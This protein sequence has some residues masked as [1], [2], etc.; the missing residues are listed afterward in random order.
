MKQYSREERWKYIWRDRGGLLPRDR[1]VHEAWDSIQVDLICL[2][3]QLINSGAIDLQTTI[4]S[5]MGAN[6]VAASV[7]HLYQRL[8]PTHH[9]RWQWPGEEMVGESGRGRRR[10]ELEVEM[11]M[12]GK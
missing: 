7:K 1:V 11:A 9:A 12:S 10:Y 6:M 4:G 3:Y 5:Q 2:A 8:A